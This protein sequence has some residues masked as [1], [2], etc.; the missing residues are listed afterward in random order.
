MEGGL[1]AQGGG[2]EMPATMQSGELEMQAGPSRRRN[3]RRG[4]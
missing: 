1:E 3:P 2:V 4:V